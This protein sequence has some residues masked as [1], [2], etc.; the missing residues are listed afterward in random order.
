MQQAATTTPARSRLPFSFLSW[1]KGYDRSWLRFD[2][3]AALTTWAL[4]VPQSIAYGQIAGLPPQA[5]LFTAFGSLL[6]YALLGTSRQLIVSPASATA[7][8]SASLIA[9]LALGDAARYWS[10][11]SLLA[12]IVGVTFI[13][14]GLLKLGF[15]SQ[16]IA[17]S[18]QAGLMFGL[19]LTII[20]GQ[21]PKLLG[22]PAADGTFINECLSIVRNIGATN[23]TTL[24]LGAASLIALLAG[25]RLA[26]KLPMPLVVVVVS[27]VVVTVLGLAGRGVDVIGDVGTQVPLPKIPSF[28]L[29]DLGALMAGAIALS[30]IGY[31]ESDTV[32]EEF[33]SKNR[34]DIKPD[35]ELVALGVANISSGVFQGFLVA[36]GASQSATNERAGAK[37]QLSGLLVGGLIFLTAAL[38]MPLFANLAQAVLGAIVI[39]AV[40]GFLNVPALRRIFQLRRGSFWLAM[41]AL[42]GVL[43]LGMLPGL[44]LAVLISALM[45][46]VAISRPRATEL[47]KLPDS[48]EF[49][50]LAGERGAQAVPG[51]VILRLDAPMIAFNAQSARNL[52]RERVRTTQPKTG[53]VL[54]DMEMS[55]DLDVGSIDKLAQIHRELQEDGVQLW[56]ARPHSEA[57]RM[58][59]HSELD[60]VIGADH[61]FQTVGEGVAAFEAQHQT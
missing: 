32:A 47:G 41:A 40:I 10:L 18:V 33:A 57:K 37:S 21:V 20:A 42:F 54:L 4:V 61:I 59:Y 28:E 16:F 60:K 11:S 44:L 22:L 36:G 49:A 17:A 14:Y 29:R 52:I 6:G 19:G 45:L 1:L 25:K 30:L 50:S 43:I 51:L 26:P 31:A 7:A 58:L 8:I 34:Y 13:V 53:V 9:P 39:S 15:V 48:T 35:Q 56:L 24:L 27:I 23:A 55:F 5:G 46:L 2:V 12:I 3:I 38:L